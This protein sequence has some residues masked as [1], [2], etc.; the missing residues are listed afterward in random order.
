[1]ATFFTFVLNHDVPQDKWMSCTIILHEKGSVI[2][3]VPQQM[4]WSFY[5]LADYRARKLK[6]RKKENEHQTQILR[7]EERA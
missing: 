7:I 6:K 3:I 1:M 2:I 4:L 5:L